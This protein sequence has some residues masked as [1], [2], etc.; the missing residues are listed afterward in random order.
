MIYS[1]NRD[2]GKVDYRLDISA[3]PHYKGQTNNFFV[4]WPG[5]LIFA[6]AIW[7]YGY[8]ANINTEI[9]ITKLK[10]NISES[11]DINAKYD[12]RHAAMNRTWTG[13]G[14]FEIGITPFIAGLFFT[15]YDQ[16]VTREFI[17]K[18]SDDYGS[19]ISRKVVKG[20]RNLDHK[21]R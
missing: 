5:F 6:P 7:G 2:Y 3:K 16:T 1:Y 14:W 17:N 9:S 12:F 4:N 20:I 13:I 8:E 18:V 21:R 19:F 10:N 15:Q 11:I